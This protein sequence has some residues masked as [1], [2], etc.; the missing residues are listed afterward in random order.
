MRLLNAK[1]IQT[2]IQLHKKLGAGQETG[3]E[4]GLGISRPA[5]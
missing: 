1:K 4:K 2:Y 5:L 3:R